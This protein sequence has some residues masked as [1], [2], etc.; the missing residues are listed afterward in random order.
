MKKIL[1]GLAITSCFSVLFGLF[2]GLS[3]N[4][5]SILNTNH[6]LRNTM[7]TCLDFSKA[8]PLER[9]VRSDLL[10]LDILHSEDDKAK[11]ELYK[12]LYTNMVQATAHIDLLIEK[13][14]S[15][16]DVKK[17]EGLNEELKNK[18]DIMMSPK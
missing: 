16:L 9:D 12:A 14:L 1:F 4:F 8:S 7:K 2:V 13:D 3:I 6:E 15:E 11:S 5:Y 17:L 18:L 10:V